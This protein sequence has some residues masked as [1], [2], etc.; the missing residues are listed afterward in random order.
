MWCWI[1]CFHWCCTVCI[2][3]FLNKPYI[4][5]SRHALYPNRSEMSFGSIVFMIIIF[6]VC[7]FN[8]VTNQFTS[9]LGYNL[10]VEDTNRKLVMIITMFWKKSNEMPGRTNAHTNIQTYERRNKR[11][12]EIYLR[13]TS[14]A[15]IFFRYIYSVHIMRCT[16]NWKEQKTEHIECVSFFWRK[17]WFLSFA[18]SRR[19]NLWWILMYF[20]SNDEQSHIENKSSDNVSI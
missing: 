8:C 11:T 10:T 6:T 16:A 18:F 13:R 2:L 12:N 1:C 14:I 3:P 20:I 19:C 4:Y 15:W 5:L 7:I 9:W 17:Q